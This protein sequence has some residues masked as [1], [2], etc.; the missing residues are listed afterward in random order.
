[1]QWFHELSTNY[2]IIFV[3]GETACQNF[4]DLKS[5]WFQLIKVSPSLALVDVIWRETHKWQYIRKYCPWN[6]VEPGLKDYGA[7]IENAEICEI[8]PHLFWKHV[9]GK[10]QPN[11]IYI[12]N[13]YIF[14]LESCFTYCLC[15]WNLYTVKMKFVKLNFNL[16]SWGS[17]IDFLMMTSSICQF[18]KDFLQFVNNR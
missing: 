3:F 15:F 4:F 16:R 17:L 11:L 8:C 5:L 7:P 9:P 10:I 1:M 13:W 18:F 6:F 2:F 12:K 14:N